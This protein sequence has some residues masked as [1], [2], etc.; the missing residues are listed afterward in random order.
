VPSP[1]SAKEVLGILQSTGL[2]SSILSQ[3]D[4]RWER[5]RSAVD[6]DVNLRDQYRGALIGGAIGDAMGRP[7]EW[8]W[9]SEARA[10]RIRAD[11]ERLRTILRHGTRSAG[12]PY[13]GAHQTQLLQTVQG[14][15]DWGIRE[16]SDSLVCRSPRLRRPQPRR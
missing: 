1:I 14:Y 15:S 2:D 6:R 16:K 5:L 9:P 12:S 7:N 3:H 11:C 4:P 10:R 8:I 13:D